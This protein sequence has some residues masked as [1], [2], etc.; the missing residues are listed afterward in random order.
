MIQDFLDSEAGA[1][2]KQLLI[3]KCEELR[4]IDNIEEFITPTHQVLE[5]KAQKKAYKIVKSML[6]SILSYD[7]KLPNIDHS[8]YAVG[9]DD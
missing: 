3:N 2:L 1:E 9:I 8:E 4:N 5:L 7:T 6:E